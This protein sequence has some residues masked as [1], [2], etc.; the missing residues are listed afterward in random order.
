M[1]QPFDQFEPEETFDPKTISEFDGND[2][3]W[4][5][6]FDHDGHEVHWYKCPFT[7]HIPWDIDCDCKECQEDDGELE[8]D[9]SDDEVDYDD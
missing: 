6:Q 9:Y 1:Y 4:I 2:C 8:S 7:G 5:Q 3:D